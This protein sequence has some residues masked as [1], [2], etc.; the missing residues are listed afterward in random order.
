MPEDTTPPP[1]PQPDGPTPAPLNAAQL[2]SLSKTEQICRIALKP[3]YLA[4]L[5]AD[6][7]EPPAEDDLTEAEIQALLT[8]C[9]T[10]RD[11][12]SRAAAATTAKT[13]YTDEE[14]DARA[15]L[16]EIIR[17]IQ[18]RARVKHHAQRPTVLLD[19]GI[20]IDLLVSRSILEQ[21][22][23]AIHLKTA[24]DIL[25]KV[26]AAKR[27]ALLDALAAYRAAQTNQTGG[28]ST[29]TQL[30]TSR[31]TLLDQTVAGRMK[32]QFSAD[33]EWPHT[34]PANHGIRMEFQLPANRPFIG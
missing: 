30:R 1:A 28:Q 15:A 25:S 21:Y 34:D 13:D 26:T 7:A 22:A 6:A 8:D 4:Q 19:Y 29:A 23:T 20:G 31:D 12:S 33:A 16:M 10:V 18:A 5:T 9:A 11:F 17:F 14:I 2:A 3:D 32:I 24:T 27:Q